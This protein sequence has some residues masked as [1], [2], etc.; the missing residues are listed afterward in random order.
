MRLFVWTLGSQ[1]GT[2]RRLMIIADIAETHDQI[3]QAWC[4]CAVDDEQWRF[5]SLDDFVTRLG[6]A[7]YLHGRA[8]RC[9]D[10]LRTPIRRFHLD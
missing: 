4:D 8:L 6:R 9:R 3:A 2:A 10:Y 5:F 7:C 1:Y